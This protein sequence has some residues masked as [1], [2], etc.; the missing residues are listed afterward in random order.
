MFEVRFVAPDLRRLD[1][2]DADVVACGVFEDERP[3][4]GLAGLLD[5]RLA[6]RL[7]KLARARFF[8]GTRGDLLALPGRPQLP[9]DKALLVG[10]GRR[11]AFDRACSEA[12]TRRLFDA[13][14]GL[15]LKKAVVELPGRG[16]DAVSPERAVD[17]LLD[18]L[19]E[20]EREAVVL[21]E[22]PEEQRRAEAQL[23]DR[24]QRTR[25]ATRRRLTP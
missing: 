14:G 22:S 1:E 2:V 23:H 11:S 6:G 15:M 19:G 20:D 5:W 7:S 10:L 9:F 24:R 4:G 3:F 21:V 13:I 12:A 18:V 8:E 17:I 25:R 16:A